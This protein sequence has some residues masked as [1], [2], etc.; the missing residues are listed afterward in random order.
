MIVIIVLVEIWEEH[1]PNISCGPVY[2]L[3]TLVAT[4]TLSFSDNYSF[5]RLVLPEF[6][7]Y[8]LLRIPERYETFLIVPKV[9]KYD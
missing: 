8:F 4:A 5:D 1:L 3:F 9:S 6:L 7:S 2:V